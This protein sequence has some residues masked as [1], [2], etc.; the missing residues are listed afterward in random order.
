MFTFISRL[1]GCWPSHCLFFLIIGVF[2]VPAAQANPISFA[3]SFDRDDRIW[4]WDFSLT[5]T[6]DATFRTWSFAGG[7]NASGDTVAA[8]GFA[9]VLS[10]FDGSG[11]LLQWDRNGGSGTRG[12]RPI[13]PTPISRMP[14]ASK[15]VEGD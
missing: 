14:S 12:A 6:Y 15:I 4:T 8:G 5:D 2:N 13:D 10:L 11:L 1:F 7:V 9:P 3:G